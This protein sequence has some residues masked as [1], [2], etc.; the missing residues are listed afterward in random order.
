MI[1]Q[2]GPIRRH[3]G[4]A[5]HGL[6][7]PDARRDF[8]KAQRVFEKHVLPKAFHSFEVA[9]TQAQQ[10]GVALDDVRCAYPLRHGKANVQPS[11]LRRLEAV[12]DQRQARVGSQMSVRLFQVKSGHGGLG[13]LRINNNYNSINMLRVCWHG[14]R[15][16]STVTFDTL[17]FVEKLEKAGVVREQAAAMAEAFK[18]ASGEAELATKGYIEPIRS[19]VRELKA[20]MSGEMKLNRLMLGAVLGLANTYH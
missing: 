3:T 2:S 6:A 14:F 19:E 17:K 20:E 5:F 4:Q 10:S 15:K 1:P 12:P 13:E 7:Q 8:S 16:M 9:L 18:D 11:Q